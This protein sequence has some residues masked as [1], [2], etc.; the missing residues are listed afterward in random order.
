MVSQHPPVPPAA[1]GLPVA[2]RLRHWLRRSPRLARLLRRMARNA[3]QTLPGTSRLLML[4]GLQQPGPDLAEYRRWLRR[5]GTLSASERAAM[6][7]AV[8]GLSDPPCIS[9]VMPVYNAP[10]AFLR[11]ALESVETQLYP[12]WQLCIADDASTAPHVQ[13]VLQAAA[14]RDRRIQVV[15]RP[16]NGHISAATNSALALAG[17]SHV[18]LMDHD[19]LLA[20]DAL[21]HVALEIRRHPDVTLI[22]T[23]EDKIDGQGRRYDLYAK[24]GWS[25]EL[26]LQ[27]NLVSH[28]GVYRRDLLERLGGLREGFEGSQDWDLALRSAALAGPGQI[29]H[30]PRPLYHWRQGAGTESFSEGALERCASRGRQA[31]QAHLGHR[32]EAGVQ[33]VPHADLPGWSRIL[34]PLPQPVPRVSL[35]LAGEPDP[36]RLEALLAGTDYPD[37]EVLPTGAASASP[38]AGGA[39]A[40]V[41]A[42]RRAAEAASGEVLLLL[43]PGLMPAEPDW[44][45]ELVSLALRPGVGAVG[46][47][48]AGPDG[49]LRHAGYVLGAGG[50]LVGENPLIRGLGLGNPGYAGQFR[51]VRDVV[52]VSGEAMAIRRALYLER[53]E[54]DAGP[55]PWADLDLGLRLREAG[56]RNLWTPYATL[57]GAPDPQGGPAADPAL[58]AAAEAM[59]RA[60]WGRALEQDPFYSPLLDLRDG[61]R[62]RAPPPWREEGPHD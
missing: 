45:R 8:A 13:A 22:F 18:A 31:V 25:P 27:Q 50:A 57:I 16:R 48:L 52:A 3:Q 47:A 53:G 60:R 34:H 5:H 56:L 20:P 23:D 55:A 38:P 39:G 61:H 15:R 9:V 37:V 1:S 59:L 42:L 41:G 10:E 58:R 2:Q 49:R 46:A 4:A 7:Q 17:G 14:A 19:D 43:A 11:A 29:R 21:F 54:A 33:V 35:I 32:G 28:L 26:L 62:L 30:I 40:G 36:A 24:P 6:L 51:L 12:H 44:L